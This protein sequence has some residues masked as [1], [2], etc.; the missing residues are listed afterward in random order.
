MLKIVW[1]VEI[2]DGRLDDIPIEKQRLIS[3]L[4]YKTAIIMNQLGQVA[5]RERKAA[6]AGELEEQMKQMEEEEEEEQNRRVL[7][8]DTERRQREDEQ[9]ST[10]L[11]FWVEQC[12]RLERELAAQRDAKNGSG[13]GDVLSTEAVPLPGRANSRHD[14]HETHPS[15]QEEATDV[16]LE[17]GNCMSATSCQCM[18]ESTWSQFLNDPMN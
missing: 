2:R 13:D 8:A 14:I 15:E 1:D 12:R 17:C 10:D 16:S 3:H 11:G 7:E 18:D 6:R 4:A 9:H 5:F